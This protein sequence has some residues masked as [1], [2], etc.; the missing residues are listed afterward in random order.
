MKQITNKTILKQGDKSFQP[1]ENMDK[2]IFWEDSTDQIVAQS[3]PHLEGVPVISLNSYTQKDIEKAFELGYQCKV[4]NGYKSNGTY[5]EDLNNAIKQINSIS[6]IE[7]DE[8]F[9]ILNYK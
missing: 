7:V 1:I 8:F 6:V 2:S 3:Q 4:D 5:Q 9:Q